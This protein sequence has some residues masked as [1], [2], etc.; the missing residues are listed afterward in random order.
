[1]HQE[2]TQ[3]FPCH[4]SCICTLFS[5]I[6]IKFEMLIFFQADVAGDLLLGLLNFQ[7]KQQHKVKLVKNSAYAGL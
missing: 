6:K 7:T 4:L 3:P 5:F 1:M 2:Q